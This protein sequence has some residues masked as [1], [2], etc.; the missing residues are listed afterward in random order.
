MREITMKNTMR[1]SH[2]FTRIKLKKTAITNVTGVWSIWNC[3]TEM[4]D[5]NAIK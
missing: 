1:Y 5:V 2:I 3:S 4:G